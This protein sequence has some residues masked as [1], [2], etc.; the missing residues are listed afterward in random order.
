MQI[1]RE[2][3]KK[4]VICTANSAKGEGLTPGVGGLRI[5]HVWRVKNFVFILEKL[6]PVGVESRIHQEAGLRSRSTVASHTNFYPWTFLY[7]KTHKPLTD[8]RRR[9]RCHGGAGRH[10]QALAHWRCQFD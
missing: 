2:A 9:A 6:N 3:I 1:V 4:R 5:Q 8:Q 10:G 7:E